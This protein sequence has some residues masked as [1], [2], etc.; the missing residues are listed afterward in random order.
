MFF[1]SFQYFSIS[2]LSAIEMHVYSCH[3][4]ICNVFHLFSDYNHQSD[5]FWN[6]SDPQLAFAIKSLTPQPL[7]NVKLCTLNFLI[8]FPVSPSTRLITSA[9]F[10][11]ILVVNLSW[12]EC[13]R[14]SQCW[15]GV[16]QLM[17]QFW[18]GMSCG[19][20]FYFSFLFKYVA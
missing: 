20:S 4:Y 1:T 7:G 17:S 3:G 14:V 19:Q 6:N 9:D 13:R 15:D 11:P 10:P 5:K 12:R 16:E 18:M 8:F 2:P